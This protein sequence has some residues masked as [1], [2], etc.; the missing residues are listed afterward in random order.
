MIWTITDLCLS[1]ERLFEE[2]GPMHPL[3]I[4]LNQMLLGDQIL[5]AIT[6]E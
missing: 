5:G 3:K 2:C 4:L 6:H 1:P